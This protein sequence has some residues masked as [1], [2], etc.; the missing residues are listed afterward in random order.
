MPAEI[1]SIRNKAR[2][3]KDLTLDYA[4]KILND[5]EHKVYSKELYELTYTTALKNAI[6]RTQE[7]TGEDGGEVKVQIQGIKYVIPNDGHNTNT[8]L[9]TTS[10]V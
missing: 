3:V 10:S 2:I 1:K 8:N 6:P 7:I 9:Q 5:T 4:I